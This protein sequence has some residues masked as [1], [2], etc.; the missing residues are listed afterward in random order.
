MLTI[1]AAKIFRLNNFEI[2][3]GN[4][5]NLVIIDLHKKDLIREESFLSKSS[6][7]PFIGAC[8]E[9]IPIMTIYNGNIVYRL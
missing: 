3:E 5:A 6:N 4:I 8:I 2:K 7:S 1:N 9:G